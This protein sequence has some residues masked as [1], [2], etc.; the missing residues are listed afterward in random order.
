MRGLR[1]K[2]AVKGPT[3]NRDEEHRRV[4]EQ[5]KAAAAAAF[6]AGDRGDKRGGEE[7]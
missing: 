7:K 2:R 6:I 1:G 5:Q 3:V 4:E